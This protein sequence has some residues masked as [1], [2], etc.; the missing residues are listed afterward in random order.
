MVTF[1]TFHGVMVKALNC[2][3]VVREFELV[4]HFCSFSDQYSWERYWS[5]LPTMVKY[6]HYSFSRSAGY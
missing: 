1:T 3:I 5:L 2:G 6:N 4:T